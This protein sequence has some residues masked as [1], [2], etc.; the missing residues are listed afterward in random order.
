V[1]PSARVTSG[2]VGLYTD[3]QQ[4]ALADLRGTTGASLLGVQ[5][6]HAGARGATRPRDRGAD[7]PLPPAQAWPLVAASPTPYTSRSQTPHPLDRAGMD[8]IAAAFAAAAVR[9]A[10][11]GADVVEVHA[12]H[13]YLLGGFCSPLT[14]RRDDAFGG[15]LDGRLRFPLAVVAAVRAAWPQDQPLAVCLSASD[16]EPGGT[17]EDE[18]VEAAGRFADAGADL[19]TV[20][21]GQTTRGSRPDYA[22]AYGAPWADLVR[23]RAG[24]PAVAVGGIPTV[25]DANGVLAAGR[26]DLCVLGHPSQ[27]E[28][29]WLHRNVG[30]PEEMELGVGPSEPGV[31]F[32]EEA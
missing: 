21:A 19:F 30:L 28:P 6:V 18:A 7:R 12:A 13:G 5:L 29:A 31:A 25:W 11:A 3:A 14:N 1:R 10:E 24:V 4:A 2:C 20:V 15:D 17:S 16:L 8:E 22:G 26:A 9:A 32:P 23:N 27:P